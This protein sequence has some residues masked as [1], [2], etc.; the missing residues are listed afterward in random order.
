[1]NSIWQ[2]NTIFIGNRDEFVKLKLYQCSNSRW[3]SKFT[4][5]SKKPR[6]SN[7][8]WD[9][10]TSWYS[11]QFFDCSDNFKY[12]RWI[13]RI[14]LQNREF[15]FF[16]PKP[17]YPLLFLLWTSR[18]CISPESSQS[19]SCQKIHIQIKIPPPVELVLTLNELYHL[20]FKIQ[21]WVYFFFPKILFRK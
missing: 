16:S 11:L 2:Q 6:F 21:E 12:L 19:Y 18:L 20:Y 17:I 15:N 5:P 3:F 4:N 10:V 8:Y 13:V 7:S 9:P 14:K 1:M